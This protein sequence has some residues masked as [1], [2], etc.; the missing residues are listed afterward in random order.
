MPLSL[1]HF[2]ERLRLQPGV[3]RPGAGAG[4]DDTFGRRQFAGQTSIIVP[5][6]RRRRRAPCRRAVALA[7][8]ARQIP[9]YRMLT[10]WLMVINDPAVA[11]GVA[12]RTQVA[13]LKRF[14]AIGGV[15][16]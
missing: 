6:G 14:D 9:Y 13:R 2:V 11:V 12:E 15:F 7:D 3:G 10:Y 5:S 1:K 8:C 4:A 16:W